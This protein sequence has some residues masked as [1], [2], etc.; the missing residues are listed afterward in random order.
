MTKTIRLTIQEIVHDFE[1]LVRYHERLDVE[2]DFEKA[3]Q[4][5][6]DRFHTD[7][8]SLSEKYLPNYR[9]H[10]SDDYFKG[11]TPAFDKALELYAN[12]Y[13]NFREMFYQLV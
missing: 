11:E 12:L 5:E 1:M 10:V 3:N 7:M 13:E 4:D 2:F 8:V 6:I 9:E